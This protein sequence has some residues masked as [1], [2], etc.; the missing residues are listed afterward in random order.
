M[1]GSGKGNIKGP[2]TRLENN[3][4]KQKRKEKERKDVQAKLQNGFSFIKNL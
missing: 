4:H 3:E 1:C 2:V